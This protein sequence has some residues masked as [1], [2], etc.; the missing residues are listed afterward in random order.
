MSEAFGANTAR[1]LPNT[2][3]RD[4]QYNATDDKLIVGTF[5]RGAWTISDAST[6]IN[7]PGVL[8]ITGDENGFA[9]DDTI[10]LVIDAANP[11]LLDVFI[12]GELEQFQLSV[13]QQINVDSLGGNDTL[14][15]DSSNGLINVLNGIRYD[16]D[17][18]VDDLELVQTGGPTH[19]SDTYSVGPAIGSGVSTI[20]G[21]VG[22]GTQV[23]FFE[24]LSPVLDLVPVAL[25]T[26][27]ATATDNA[28]NYS[29]GSLLTTGLVTIDEHEPIEFANKTALTINAG[30]GTD[31]INLD[32]SNTP[33][34]LTGGITVNGDDP[35]GGDTL[36]VTGAGAETVVYTPD[37]FDGGTLDLTS[38]SVT[39]N[40]IEVLSYDGQGDNDSLTVVGTGGDDTIVHTPGDQ[41]SGRQLPG[42]QPARAQLPESRER[43][44]PDGR[45][46]RRQR[47]AGVQ[48][49]RCQ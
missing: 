22:A 31:T 28:I 11:S 25:L 29:V 24:D 43:R 38:L 5:G 20:V 35:P 26:V 14:I 19:V 34:G 13:I 9:E 47:H 21:G 40:T 3:V 12:N 15:V 33:T 48:R 17:G 16:G 32:N 39:I 6:T 36:I 45:R 37:A 23:V 46:R 44:Q 41:R 8:V 7:D 49:H 10:R 1:G 27:D 2:V 18:G 42:Q 30:A 4:V